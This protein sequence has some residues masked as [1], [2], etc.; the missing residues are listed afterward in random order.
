MRGGTRSQ[1]QGLPPV[2]GAWERKWRTA[3]VDAV[4]RGCY[5]KLQD[6]ASSA[7][8]RRP[9]RDVLR[10]TGVGVLL[11]DASL[12]ALSPSARTVDVASL[13]VSKWREVAA[14]QKLKGDDVASWFEL[15]L[16]GH[17]LGGYKAGG[18]VKAIG[19][20]EVWLQSLP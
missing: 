13:A 14:A 12:W 3:V 16:L 6:L 15:P 19:D 2:R 11:A 10:S 18:F 17:P 8:S 9:E 5:G 7:M 1:Q 20:V 4:S